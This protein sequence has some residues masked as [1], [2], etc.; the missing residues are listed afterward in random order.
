[1]NENLTNPQVR[2]DPR[3]VP[4]N[5]MQQPLQPHLQQPQ[6][7]QPFVAPQVAPPIQPAPA[8]MQ[9]SYNPLMR[10]FRQPAAYITLTS[11]GQF[12]AE[13]SVEIPVTGELPVYP[14]TAKDEI[15]LRTPDALMNGESVVKVIESCVPNIKNAWNMPS[16]D[17]DSTLIAIRIAS[18]GREMSVSSKC[19]H[20]GE[21]NDYDL[22]LFKILSGV[23][24][25]DYNTPV[26]TS[27]GLSVKLRPLS[28]IQIT[29]SSNVAFEEEKLIQ[30]L[31]NEELTD[32]QRKETFF[33]HMSRM[34]DVNFDN[35]TNCTLSITTPDG[36]EVTDSKFIKEFYQNSK[37][38]TNREIEDKIKEFANE[39]SIKAEDTLCTSCNEQFK[40]NV[41]FDYSRFFAKG[42]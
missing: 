35:L 7:S 1:M 34:V 40:L 24:M 4:Q 2:P 28:Y 31:N 16:V 3:A 20:C 32:E 38:S 21:E 13:D 33:K 14:M 12:W 18:Y 9:K 37:G 36:I 11:K 27:D 23:K 41:E 19:P 25:P 5:F 22:D 42:S 10:H 17:V 39:V 8:P 30:S 26:I 29:K 15:I 6:V